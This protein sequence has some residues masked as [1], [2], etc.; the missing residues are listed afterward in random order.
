MQEPMNRLFLFKSCSKMPQ[1]QSF[2]RFSI[3]NPVFSLKIRFS[4]KRRYVLVRGQLKKRCKNVSSGG[5]GTPLALQ[6][7]QPLSWFSTKCETRVFNPS[8][9][10]LNFKIN[11]RI[12]LGKKPYDQNSCKFLMCAIPGSNNSL[13]RKKDFICALSVTVFK[14]LLFSKQFL[15]G[16]EPFLNRFRKVSSEQLLP[17]VTRFGFS[18]RTKSVH[19][20]PRRKYVSKLRFKSRR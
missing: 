8:R 5:L 12:W 20:S 2:F 7:V 17:L 13:I 16:V 4:K 3:E 18:F 10:L 15:R 9:L 11:S 6:K 14:I 1:N 19:A